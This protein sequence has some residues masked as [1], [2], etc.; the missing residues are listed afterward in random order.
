MPTMRDVARLAGVSVQT[1][2]CVVNAKPGITA[3]TRAKVWQAIKELGYRPYSIARSLRTRH[4]HTIALF[5]TDI[6]NPSLATMAGAAEDHAHAFGYSMVLYNTHGDVAREADYMRT[7]IERWVDG[8]LIIAVAEQM[9]GLV[10]L[11]EAGIP[12]VAID[13]VPVEH[14]GPTVTLDNVKA[15]WLAAGH[16][17][18]LGHTRI[19]HISGPLSLRLARE[20]LAGFQQAIA[21]R[22][23]PP[24]VCVS[25]EGMWECAAGYR[26]MQR[27]LSGAEELSGTKGAGGTSLPTAVFAAN[28]RMAFGAMRAI[29]EAGLRVPHDISVVGLDDI[30]VAAF[31]T[32]PLTTVRQSFTKMATLGVQL[33]LELLAGRE[34]EQPHVVLEPELIVRHSTAAPG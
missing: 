1:V 28:D 9:P 14:T 30:E 18:D 8:V 12:V 29:D 16:L 24:G 13:R 11:H 23:L 19:A 6:V 33:L 25:G 4:T 7:A 3:E 22:G 10:V 21:A 5:V 32:P 31:Q 2:S 15:G 27:I 20:R 17:L 26:A 34:P